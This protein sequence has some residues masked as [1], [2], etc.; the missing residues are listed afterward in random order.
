MRSV[1]FWNVIA[2]NPAQM[3]RCGD[4]EEAAFCLSR[5]KVQTLKKKKNLNTDVHTMLIRAVAHMH[6]QHTHT[7][8]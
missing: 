1:C 6:T 4:E 8:R 2:A 7:H 3:R 5:P